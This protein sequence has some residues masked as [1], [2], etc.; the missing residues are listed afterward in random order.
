MKK[1]SEQEASRYT[2]E[3]RSFKHYKSINDYKEDVVTCLVYSPW[4]Y[5]E[6]R[7]RKIVEDERAE[8]VKT[9]Y[10]EKEPAYDCCAEVGFHCG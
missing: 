6:E 7:A 9:A 2:E 10:A 5:S 3:C 1:M 4:H 8:Y